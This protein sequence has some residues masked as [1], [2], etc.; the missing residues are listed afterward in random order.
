MF[1]FLTWYNITAHCPFSFATS[2]IFIISQH[3]LCLHIPVLYYLNLCYITTHCQLSFP[4]PRFSPY[5]SIRSVDMSQC[6]ITLPYI[7]L[8]HTVHLVLP[9]PIF[10]L[11]PS[12]SYANTSQYSITLP[13]MTLL[14]TSFSFSISQI[15][16]LSQH[17][18]S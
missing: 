15:F 2:H 17:Q 14:H 4:Y 6:Y 9:H 13:H 1:Y 11:Y 16:T 10:S 18:L 5:H 8:L 12:I 7:T 3:Q